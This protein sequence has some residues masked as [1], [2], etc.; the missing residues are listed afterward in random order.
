MSSK[1]PRIELDVDNNLNGVLT[2]TCPECSNKIKKNLRELS[3]GKEVSCSCGFTV[4]FTGDDLRKTQ[5]SLDDLKKAL[6]SFG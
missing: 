5:K 1:E 3:P 2:I 6:K 4:S